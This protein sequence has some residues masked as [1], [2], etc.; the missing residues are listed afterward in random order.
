MGG[1][2]TRVH[3]AKCEHVAYF[4]LHYDAGPSC[5]IRSIRNVWKYRKCSFLTGLIFLLTDLLQANHQG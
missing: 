2:G 1:V 3:Y 5:F 4:T